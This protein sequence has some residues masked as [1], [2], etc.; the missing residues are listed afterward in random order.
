MKGIGG[1]PVLVVDHAILF[2]V[3]LAVFLDVFLTG[4]DVEVAV[5]IFVGLN[6]G[7]LFLVVVGLLVVV[8]LLVVVVL[9]IKERVSGGVKI[10]TKWKGTELTPGRGLAMTAVAT[11]AKR[12]KRDVVFM[13]FYGGGV[14]VGWSLM[15]V[16]GD[17]KR[18]TC[19][20]GE[21]VLQKTAA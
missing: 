19:V 13:L 15:C 12:A 7:R 20:G 8:A 3:H 21:R 14:R 1:V 18:L 16:K 10:T 9:S 4:L 17:W 6:V 11:T 5:P 2:G